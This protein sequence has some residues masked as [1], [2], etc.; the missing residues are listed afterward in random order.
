MT[1]RDIHD[2]RV[3][4]PAMKAQWR[5]WKKNDAGDTLV[6][7][8]LALI[9]L[10]LASVALIIAF[11][12]SISASAD[13]RSIANYNTVLA[14]ADADVRSQ[15][16]V[17]PSAFF[18][19]CPSSWK[20]LAYP[21]SA[22]LDA[23]LPSTDTASITMVQYWDGTGWSSSCVGLTDPTQLITIQI[24]DISS[25]QQPQ[26][27][28][29][30]VNDPSTIPS[31]QGASSTAAQLVFVTEPAGAT[32][33]SA[34][35][36][37]PVVE[38]ESSTGQLVNSNLSYITMTILSGPSGATLSSCSGTESSGYV[39]F[40]GCALN[41]T[42]TYQLV[43][44]LNAPIKANDITG[45]SDAF[46]VTATQ[47][48]TPVIT[49]LVPPTPGVVPSTTTPGAVN[50]TFTPSSNAPAGQSYTVK[51]CT[52]NAMSLGCVAQTGFTSGSDLDNLYPGT[53][54]YVQVTATSSTDYLPATSPPTG[55]VP[56][57]IQLLSPGTPKL[58][59]G[60]SPGSINVVF[61]PSSNAAAGQTYTV[62]AC[63]SIN[64]GCI[65][66]SNF[67]SGADFTGLAFTV[68]SAGSPYYVEVVANASTGYLV[69]AAST[70]VVQKDTSQVAA[71]GQPTAASS[72]T[73]PGVINATFSAS[74]GVAPAGYTA[75]ACTGKNPL[76]GCTS[77]ITALPGG[78]QFTGLTQGTPYYIAIT[79]LPPSSAYAS[80]TSLPSSNAVLATVQLAV[81]STPVLGYGSVAGSI[82]VTSA[83]S[84]APAGQT[85][86]VMACTNAGMTN[87]GCV[88]NSGFT[89][90]S[91]LIGL[92]DT[93][94][95]AG[96]LYFVEVSANSSTGYLGSGI[97]TQASHADTS[98]LAIPGTPSATSSTT[99]AGTLNV[100]FTPST[101]QAPN[102]YTVLAC[103]SSSMTNPGCVGPTTIA[104]GGGALS[105]LTQG[106][107]YYLSI[108]AV[109]TNPAYVS[110]TSGTSS[111]SVIATVQ[112]A[113]ATNVTVVPSATTAGALSVTFG[114]PSNAPSGQTY[115][116]EICTNASMTNP[117][118]TA[119]SN[120][121]SG[122][123]ITGFT[124]GT[125]YYATVTATGSTGYLASTSAVSAAGVAPIQLA[126]PGTPSATSSTTTAGTLNVTFTPSTGQA[127]NSY[128]VLACTSSSMTNP[129]CVGPTTIASGGG[130]LSG[131]TQGSK[132]YL[133]ITAVST[134]P[135]YVSN[136]SGTSSTSVMATV[137]LA[138]PLFTSITPSTTTTGVIGVVFAGSSNAPVGQT[139]TETACTNA[140]MTNPGCVGP[141]AIASGGGNVTGLT[142]GSLYYIQINAPASAGYLA[143]VSV[144]SGPTVATAQ[145]TTPSVSSV[146]TTTAGALTVNVNAPTN[147]PAGQL[148]AMTACTSSAMTNPGCVIATGILSG[149]QITG[150]TVGNSYYV[151]VVASASPGYL[152]STQSATTATPVMATVQLTTPVINSVARS[153][154]TTLIV[155]FTG[156]TN[157]PGTQ[158]YSVEVCTS[159]AMTNPGCVTNANITSGPTT[160]SSLVS[161][162]S[163]YVRV[164]AVASVGYLL[165]LS[166]INGPTTS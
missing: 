103:T 8:L 27:I 2:G 164:T 147:A 69:S 90:G 157:G 113:A 151:D 10:S 61:A 114:A 51:A 78:T 40:S 140:G 139:Y 165:A 26:L 91:N 81:P 15:I 120:Y 77:P 28:Q 144:A 19:S 24:S 106:S 117:G 30:V 123:Q 115:S 16:Q 158:T 67:T 63:T 143:Q 45:Y 41:E 79:A 95:T 138:A 87:P 18:G 148:Y 112:L 162:T 121:A 134:N 110:N 109:S 159:S 52:D 99:T 163:Y 42:G 59:Y 60:S 92:A 58:A 6:E 7:V 97:S 108:T 118:C 50:V 152:V 14:S 37:Q 155:N 66:N 122:T 43:A 141:A 82:T 153:G 75:Q 149:G 35:A 137:Q 89:S 32:Y 161:R 72:A 9:V 11:G 160:F 68:G 98:Q 4:T 21:T 156:S 17:N 76:S 104:S 131:L 85:Y 70:Q 36:T 105:G 129:G 38:V 128:T 55:P 34:F 166:S 33:N 64:S 44:T 150:L 56:A 88:T 116:V 135:A 22:E 57:T 125:T 124:G 86:T 154:N 25:K 142:P 101:G 53:S 23:N 96:A 100:T 20:N 130:A 13:H 48:G 127:P 107:K 73:T 54:Y 65:T 146:V 136:T 31:A 12:T 102:S 29:I 46:S 133:S 94:G 119:T 132:Y 145:L 93:P 5:R 80:N 39:Y 3:T 49:G 74:T 126:A 111:T 84:N 62:T 47:L 83:S 71:P 1:K